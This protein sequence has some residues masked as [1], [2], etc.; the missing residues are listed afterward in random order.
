[1]KHQSSNSDSILYASYF[2]AGTG[3]LLLVVNFISCHI[4]GHPIGGGGW[5]WLPLGI[6]C[7]SWLAALELCA[8]VGILLRET[9]PDPPEWVS[10]LVLT[11]L[12]C[13]VLSYAVRLMESDW[14]HVHFE[15]MMLS[16]VCFGYLRP[17]SLTRQDNL[18]ENIALCAAFAILYAACCL[19]T[20][21]QWVRVIPMLGFVCQMIRLSFSDFAKKCVSPNWMRILI[22]LSSALSMMIAIFPLAIG[23]YSLPMIGKQV[24]I[25]LVQPVTVWLIYRLADMA[26]RNG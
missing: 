17:N 9:I 5:G 22:I 18:P 6:R 10:I 24:M 7:L 2:L 13:G 4:A 23:R 12:V 11:I 25:L 21:Y 26:K 3:S 19:L 20:E 8:W 16:C 15:T 14:L 1:M